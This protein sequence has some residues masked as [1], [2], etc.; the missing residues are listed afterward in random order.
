MFTDALSTAREFTRAV[1]ISRRNADGT[2]KAGIGSFIVVN[3]G[4]WIATAWHI[5]SGILELK[6]ACDRYHADEP[7][8]NAIRADTKMKAKEKRRRLAKLGTGEADCPTHFSSWWG[9]DGVGIAEWHA[10]PAIDLVVARL[11]NF[12]SGSIVSY[13]AFKDPAKGMTQGASLCKLGFPFHTVEP[14]YDEGA[15]RFTFP[16][17]AVPPPFFPIDGIYTREILVT[18]VDPPP[19]FPLKYVETSTP[20]L[21]GQSGGPTVDVHGAVWAVQSQTQHYP[22]GFGANLKSSGMPTRE[23]EFLRNQYLNVGWG[24]H[25]ESVI[26]VLSANGIA[27]QISAH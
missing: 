15:D 3:D 27:V 11:T 13:P 2:C 25:S 12:D 9:W 19:P 22:L 6:E 4:G 20:G 24:I 10:V 21:M 8:R 18:G 26:G 5:I 7:A 16:R 23:Q 17:G 1:V 14:S